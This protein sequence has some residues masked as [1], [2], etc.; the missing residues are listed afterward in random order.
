MRAG[1]AFLQFDWSKSGLRFVSLRIFPYEDY[2]FKF[3]SRQGRHRAA[4]YVVTDLLLQT[5]WGEPYRAALVLSMSTDHRHCNL[6]SLSHRFAVRP[7]TL[8]FHLSVNMHVFNV[9]SYTECHKNKK[10]I[11]KAVSGLV[12]VPVSKTLV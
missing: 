12:S 5:T 7:T 1:P 11:K 3:L 6:R 10:G 9:K 2:S 8:S 4:L